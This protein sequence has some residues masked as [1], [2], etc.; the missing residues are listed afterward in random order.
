MLESKEELLLARLALHM[1]L[2]TQEQI[3]EVL[4]QRQQ[5]PA[6][7]QDLGSFLLT[8]GYL[9]SPG[10]AALRQAY[11][12]YLSKRDE[13]AAAAQKPTAPSP[14]PAVPQAG[15]PAMA[16]GAAAPAAPELAPL[17]Y[18]PG[19]TPL[20]DLLRQ[21]LAAGASD[22]H[23]HPG[24]PLKLRVDGRLR[25]ASPALLEPA[26]AERLIL[27]VLDAAARDKLAREQQLDFAHALPGVGRFRASAYRTQNGLDGVF[28]AIPARVPTLADLGLP[29]S[30]AAVSRFHQGLVLITGPAGCGK[31]STMAALVQEVAAA[32]PDHVITFEEPIEYLLAGGRG[33]INQRAVGHHTASFARALRGALREDP[34]VIV[35]GELRDLETIQLALTAA[36]TG[37]LVFGTLHTSSALRTINRLLGVF[38]PQQ[39]TQIRTMLSESL[40][41]V[42]SQRLVVRADGRGRVPVVEVLFNTKAVGNLIRESK[43]FQIRSIMQTGSAHGMVLADSSLLEHVKAGRISREEALRHAEDPRK[44]GAA[45]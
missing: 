10:F 23:L 14:A 28:R 11:S 15:A 18:R 27:S 6:R 12:R 8:R 31:S 40:R 13:E 7:G 37:H 9:T 39:Q 34:D 16:G 22:L 33:L 30:V 43:V 4:R 2:L 25:D 24:A 32:R 26:E 38:P 42:V 35:I 3:A 1:K 20:E 36:E 21:T 41:A 45:P 17:A 19:A 29:E 5:E 44:L